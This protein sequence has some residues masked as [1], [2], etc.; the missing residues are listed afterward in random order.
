MKGGRGGRDGREGRGEL[1]ACPGASYGRQVLLPI[2]R[3]GPVLGAL[4]RE[5]NEGNVRRG[6]EGRNWMPVIAPQDWWKPCSPGT[7]ARTR[8]GRK[9]K[10]GRREVGKEWDGR[11]G[12][13]GIEGHGRKRKEN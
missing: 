10:K 3:L 9:G 7:S 2:D 11:N 4:G 12:K 5:G 8:K 6:E 13:N 1:D